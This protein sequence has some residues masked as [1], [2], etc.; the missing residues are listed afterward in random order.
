M[1]DIILLPTYNERKNILSLV[2]KIFKL[3]P[4]IRILVIDDNS[5]DG[6]AR[7]VK[8]LMKN[9]SNLSILERKQKTGLKNAYFEAFKMT[10]ENKKIRSVITMDADWSHSPEYIKNFLD[11]IISSDLIIGSRYTKGGGVFKWNIWRRIISRGGNFYAQILAG[12]KINDAT[13]GFMC[14]KRELLEQMDFNCVK[15]SGYGFLIELKFYLS[16]ISKTGVREI[17][18]IFYDRKEGVT[19]FSRQ[20]FFEALFVP[21][22]LLAKRLFLLKKRPRTELDKKK[23]WENCWKAQSSSLNIINLGRKIYNFFIFKFLKKY[24]S[25]QA[26]FLELGCGTASLGLEI[27]KIAKTY[28]GFDFAENALRD[29]ETRFKKAGRVNY[30]F[31]AVNVADFEYKKKFDIVWSQGLVEHF[32]DTAFLINSHLKVCKEG[33]EVIISVPAKYSYHYFWHLITRPKPFRKFWPWPDQIFISKKMFAKHMKAL[34]I[35]SS[36]YKIMY[37]RPSILGLLILIIKK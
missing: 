25:K 21:W 23:I 19:K 20:I 26:D 3:Y 30:K 4:R 18:I 12:L 22:R 35:D 32:N 6:T 27:S 33:G 29:A 31:E 37:L 36:K 14:I 13:S 17:P 8:E 28:T 7:S 34:K 5:P 16:R 24:I 1:E 2:P 10:R 15:A 9:Y 11:N